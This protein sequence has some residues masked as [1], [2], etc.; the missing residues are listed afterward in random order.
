ME[1][2]ILR[3]RLGQ[4]AVEEELTIIG[5]LL[6]PTAA[7]QGGAGGAAAWQAFA[8]KTVLR[9][10]HDRAHGTSNGGGGR[11]GSCRVLGGVHGHR[12][13]TKSSPDRQRTYNQVGESSCWG[14]GGGGASLGLRPKRAYHEI[15]EAIVLV[16]GWKPAERLLIAAGLQCAAWV[17]R[18]EDSL[19]WQLLAWRSASGNEKVEALMAEAFREP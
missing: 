4:V 2:C 6:A 9:C 8:A 5:V 18:L 12:H 15:A 7:L 10:V 11:R 16:V 13:G 19:V 17:R 3:T 1:F 14:S